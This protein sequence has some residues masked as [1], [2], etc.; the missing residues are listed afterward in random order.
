[1]PIIAIRSVGGA[2][3]EISE[4][5]TAYAYRQ[6]ELMFVTTTIGP[7]PVIEAT[8]PAR[9][10]L[11]ATLAPHVYGAYANFLSDADVTGVYP[12]GTYER[13][14]RIKRQYDPENVFAAN[15]NVR[16]A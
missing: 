11:W 2:V 13:L 14:A 9:E 10:Q 1:S 15:H 12:A 16:P 6:A 8:R 7:P 3:S 4:S 5:A